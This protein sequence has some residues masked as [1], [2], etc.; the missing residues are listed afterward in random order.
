MTLLCGCK[1]TFMPSKK[2]AAGDKKKRVSSLKETGQ[3]KGVPY[4][5]RR[6]SLFF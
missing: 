3:P 1:T 4:E 2:K 5:W 6:D